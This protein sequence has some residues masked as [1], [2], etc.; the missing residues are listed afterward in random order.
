M[1]HFKS[2]AI[3]AANR[4]I[5]YSHQAPTAQRTILTGRGNLR[6]NLR[7]AISN[8]MT[9]PIEKMPIIMVIRYRYHLMDS[10]RYPKPPRNTSFLIGNAQIEELFQLAVHLRLACLVGKK[11]PALK[12]KGGDIQLFP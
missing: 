2:L 5:S 9:V 6:P 3:V 1:F 12:V 7:K 8:Q 10:S 11:L 4:K